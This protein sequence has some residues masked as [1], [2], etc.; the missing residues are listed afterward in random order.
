MLHEY[1][2]IYSDRFYPL[3]HV[4]AVELGTYYLWL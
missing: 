2:V 1:H 3:F 4:I